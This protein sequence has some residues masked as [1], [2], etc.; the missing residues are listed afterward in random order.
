M[1][2]KAT[3]AMFMPYVK[4]NVRPYNIYVRALFACASVHVC[5]LKSVVVILCLFLRAFFDNVSSHD[6]REV[7][8]KR[9]AGKSVGQKE[10]TVRD[11][12]DIECGKAKLKTWR[13]V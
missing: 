7:R 10:E 2:T 3:I 13:N 11:V 12:A 1:I 5:P 8:R 9:N 4:S 6:M